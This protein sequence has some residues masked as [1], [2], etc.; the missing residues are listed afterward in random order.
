MQLYLEASW[1]GG[2][3]S[4][5]KLQQSFIADVR[6]GSKYASSIGFTLEKVY[7]MSIFIWYGQGRLQKLVIAFMFLELIK[8]MLA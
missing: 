5:L 2:G 6:L 8:N 1:T 3:A 7:R 4:W